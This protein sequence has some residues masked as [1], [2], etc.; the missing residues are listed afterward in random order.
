MIRGR[1]KAALLGAVCVPPA[2]PCLPLAAVACV[3]EL[4][5]SSLRLSQH[6]ARVQTAGNKCQTGLTAS[7]AHHRLQ[8]V[9]TQSQL[10]LARVMHFAL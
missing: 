9:D 7:R 2:L 10:H 3:A 4:C 8:A 6:L 1:L 5:C